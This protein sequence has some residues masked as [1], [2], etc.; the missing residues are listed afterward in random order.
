VFDLVKSDFD[1]CSSGS[2]G[3]FGLVKE[4]LNRG[5][6]GGLQRVFDLVK[7]DFDGC[8]GGS[9]GVRRRSGLEGIALGV[10]KR[11]R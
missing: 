7:S 10:E 9:Q 1:G 8:S 11:L 2:Q 4:R 6:S 5:C 3:V